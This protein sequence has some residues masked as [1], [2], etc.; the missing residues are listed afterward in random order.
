MTSF[1][2]RSDP[3]LVLTF[4]ER[5]DKACLAFRGRLG[6][7]IDLFGEHI[8]DLHAQTLR[9]PEVEVSGKADAVIGDAQTDPTVALSFQLDA[10]DPLPIARNACFMA[11][12]TSSVTIRPQGMAALNFPKSRVISKA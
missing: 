11:F 6:P 2:I 12:E 5:H 7:G 4:L 10:N 1:D 3:L 8:H 9:F